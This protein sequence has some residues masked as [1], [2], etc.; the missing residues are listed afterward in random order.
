VGRQL[1][2]VGDF[3]DASGPYAVAATSVGIDP[4]NQPTASARTGP[5][6][7]VRRPL[8]SDFAHPAEI[9]LARIFSFYR[10]R[11]MY[12]PTTFHL[13]L[14]ETGRP[15]EQVTPDFYLPD[16]DTYVELTTMRQSLVTRKNRKIRRLKELF[17]S[18][19]VKLVYRKDYDRLVGSLLASS[20]EDVIRQPGKPLLLEAQIREQIEHLADHIAS[21]YHLASNGHPRLQP[22]MNGLDADAPYLL[23]L[24]A[25]TLSFL[26]A[27]ERAVRRRVTHV[28]CDWIELSRF[29]DAGPD[30]RVRLHRRPCVPVSSRSVI[31]VCDVVSSGLSAGFAMRWLERHGARQVEVCTLLD[32]EEARILDVPIALAGFPAP[33]EIMV[34]FGIPFQ[35]LYADL[36]FVAALKLPP[37]PRIRAIRQ[38]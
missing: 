24:G 3:M 8:D 15:L 1:D 35:G 37:R 4:G 16:Y 25:G 32:R 6:P 26:E 33:R 10:V 22:P 9:D 5:H 21:R 14:D 12:E 20:P 34:G 2:I 38:V 11:W 36:P 13:E 23:G 7:L 27:I 29:S 28:D 17:P 30:E 18:L 19:R 31:L